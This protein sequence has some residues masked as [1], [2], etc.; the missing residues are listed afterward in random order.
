VRS[1]R[2][3][4]ALRL[5][6]YVPRRRHKSSSR[7]CDV[8][9]PKILAY[10]SYRHLL[11]ISTCNEYGIFSFRGRT[12]YVR[13]GANR[14]DIRESGSLDVTSRYNI[15]HR[16][17]NPTLLTNDIALIE[18]PQY[19]WFSGE[20]SSNRTMIDIVNTVIHFLLLRFLN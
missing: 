12:Y 19:V 15:V 14:L 10:T 9:C 13:L 3:S 1:I 11:K 4:F 2:S 16:D 17:Y 18:L 7:L 6:Q 5:T 20:C 8:T